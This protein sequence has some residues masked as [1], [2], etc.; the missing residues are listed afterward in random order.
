VGQGGQGGGGDE[1]AG[2]PDPHHRA[3]CGAEPP[4]ADVHPAVEQDDHQRHR[5]HPLDGGD[6]QLTQ[7]WHEVRGQRGGEQ[8]DR[9]CW[10]PDQFADPVGQHRRGDGDGNDQHEQREVF[11]IAHRRTPRV[12]NCLPRSIIRLVIQTIRRDLS[13]SAWID[14][15]PNLS[16]ADPCGGG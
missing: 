1:G 9:R 15:A 14:E 3:G 12:L 10:D 2:N 7:R 5:H 16:R 6:R 11:D 4:P 8:E 13:R